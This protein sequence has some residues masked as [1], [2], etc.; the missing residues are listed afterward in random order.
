[1]LY[2]WNVEDANAVTHSVFRSAFASFNVGFARMEKPLRIRSDLSITNGYRQD[3]CGSS[4]HVGRNVLGICPPRLGL[5]GASSR[6]TLRDQPTPDSPHRTRSRRFW[7][8]LAILRID[9][10]ACSLEG[11]D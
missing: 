1:M 3:G 4:D 7:R 2:W 6:G 11:A 5:P 10:D 9:C 8:R